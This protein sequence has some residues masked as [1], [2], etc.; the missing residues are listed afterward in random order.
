MFWAD[1]HVHSEYSPDSSE[2]M[3]DIVKRA[4]K[5]GLDELAFTDHLDYFF[6]E[7]APQIPCRVID[8]NAYKSKVEELRESYGHKISLL[9]GVELGLNENLGAEFS[10]LASSAG[11]D[12]IIGSIHDVRGVD[13]YLHDFF[14]GKTKE[15]GYHEY[16]EYLLKCINLTPEIN[17]VGHM[18]FIRRYYCGKNNSFDF[19]KYSDVIEEILK[20]L[21]S[22]GRGL[23]INTSGIRYGLGQF[24]PQVPILKRFKELN[25]EIIT[26]GSDAHKLVHI[27]DEFD[28]ARQMLIDVGFRYISRFRKGISYPEKIT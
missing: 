4:V 19:C 18:D 6:S 28:T 11:F 1:Y 25:G 8:F 23:E 15:Q 26:L 9:F 17:T 12:Y 24:H 2:K 13:L 14:S 7:S 3:T 27:A 16:L 22:T 5:L 10:S 21:I 20:T